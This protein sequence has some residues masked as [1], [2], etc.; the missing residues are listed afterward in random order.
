VIA[1]SDTKERVDECR[2]RLVGDKTGKT[3]DKTGKIT[4]R[5][6]QV[7]A[8]DRITGKVLGT[9]LFQAPKTC[10]TNIRL[11]S[12]SAPIDDVTSTVEPEQ[13]GVWAAT[14]AK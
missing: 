9:K 14:F 3:I 2:H 11:Y 13:I 12:E 6:A 5:D 7:T 10:G 8:Y 4:M 1:L